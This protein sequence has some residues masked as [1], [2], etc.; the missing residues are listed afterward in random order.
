MKRIA[1]MWSLLWLSA[2]SQLPTHIDR[3]ALVDQWVSQ[4]QYRRAEELLATISKSDPQFDALDRQRKAL[5]SLIKQFEQQVLREVK[6]LAAQHQWVEAIAGLD[7][8][9]Q[10]V[11]GDS[12]L[13]QANNTLLAERK[14]YLQALNLE[15]DLLI[16]SQLPARNAI[17][18]K[19]LSAD[20]DSFWTRWKLHQQRR[21]GY[22]L[23]D[24][25]LDCV[26][27]AITEKNLEAANSCLEPVA[28]VAKDDQRQRLSVS[29]QRLARELQR[30][31]RQ[32]AQQKA[33]AERVLQLQRLK[34]EY[35][36]MIAA[37]W[38]LAAR[39]KMNQL[40]VHSPEDNE[41]VKWQGELQQI[42]GTQVELGIQ[43]GQALYSQGFLRQALEVWRNTAKLSPD[44]TVLQAHIQ[45]AERFIEKLQRLES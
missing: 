45:R 27:D 9:R 23:A 43:Q 41:V 31:P 42:I 37:G 44:N 32:I 17:L 19:M 36:D 20:P 18:E 35:R 28:T 13:H 22:E 2:C 1:I 15:L 5:P 26:D 33:D 8:A 24:V 21:L 30:Q 39:E 14:A 40:Q 29:Q 34:Q 12:A 7:S 38:W 25:L 3:A 10:Q 11:P 4:Q 16:A 6:S